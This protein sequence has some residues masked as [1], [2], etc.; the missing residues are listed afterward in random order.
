MAKVR[1]GVERRKRRVRGKLAAVA[2]GRPRLSVFR[3]SKNIYAQII[4][5]VGGRTLA[6]ASSIVK[7]IRGKLKTGADTEAAKAVGKLIAE[8]ATGTGISNVIFEIPGHVGH[9]AHARVEYRHRRLERF[10]PQSGDYRRRLSR[11]GSR[12]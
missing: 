8:R 5:D 3:S 1:S 11:R 7:E 4:D 2:N 12:Q 6:A 9:V 10:H